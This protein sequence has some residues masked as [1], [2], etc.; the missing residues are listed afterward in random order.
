ML[1]WKVRLHKLA[2]CML[3]IYRV[4]KKSL[5]TWRLQYSTQLMSWRWPSQNTFELWTVLYWT[6]SSRT[7]FSV[8]ISVWRLAEDTLNITCNILCCNHQV[9]RDFLKTLYVCSFYPAVLG[10]VLVWRSWEDPFKI[11][12]PL[13]TETQLDKVNIHTVPT[14]IINSRNKHVLM[15]CDKNFK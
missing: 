2:L 12:T 5:C 6:L 8:S 15:Y 11:S 13:R 4:I 7:Q 14:Y 3:A 9:H 10:S 1:V